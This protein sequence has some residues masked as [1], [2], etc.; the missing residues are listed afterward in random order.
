MNVYTHFYNQGDVSFR[1]RTLL[2]FGDSW[3]IIGT[4]VMKNPGTAA[5]I[6]IVSDS[7][8]LNNLERFDNS[9][10]SWFEFSDDS[11]MKCVGDLFAYYYEKEN[12]HQLNGIIQIFNLFYVKDGNL[13]NALKKE[14][15]ISSPFI[16]N[17]EEDILNYDI[18]HLVMPI[19]LGFSDLAFNKKFRKRAESFFS[20]AQ[21]LGM[22]Y[23][24]PEFEKNKFVHPQ[25]LM[26]FRKN[27][28][29]SIRIRNNF[30]NNSF[31]LK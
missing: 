8:I 24:C 26:L 9:G 19:Y 11:T 1:W 25:S 3:N 21:S 4:A 15:N 7:S 12:R 31:D 29:D 18:D 16:F 20:R 17:S 2:Q 22:K 10:D 14:N 30:K 13:F 27:N 6:S 23:C 28:E 5:P